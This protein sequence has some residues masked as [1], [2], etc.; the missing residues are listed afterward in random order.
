MGPGEEPVW[1]RPILI[2]CP[3]VPPGHR[4]LLSPPFWYVEGAG[5]AAGGAVCLCVAAVR[6]IGGTWGSILDSWRGRAGPGLEGGHVLG[7][8][9][10][11]GGAP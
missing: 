8:V 7:G 6:S 4:G 2:S 5:I 11:T 1:D 3:S 9:V 10:L